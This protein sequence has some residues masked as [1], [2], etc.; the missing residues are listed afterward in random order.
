[1]KMWLCLLQK[2]GRQSLHFIFKKRPQFNLHLHSVWL[3][4]VLTVSYTHLDVYKRQGIASAC[5]FCHYYYYY[6]YYS[7]G[8]TYGFG[9][10]RG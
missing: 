1:M 6:Y 5:A 4:N 7:Q 8:L 3:S 9:S 10:L 2:Q